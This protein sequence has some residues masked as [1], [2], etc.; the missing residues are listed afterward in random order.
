MDTRRVRRDVF[1]TAAVFAL[2]GMMIGSWNARIPAVKEHL[3]VSLGMMG[4]I[5]LCMGLGSL[6][7]MPFTGAVLKRVDIRIVNTALPLVAGSVFTLLPHVHN[8]GAFAAL[9]ALTGFCWGAWDV[10]INVQAS[11]VERESKW[12]IMPALHG[13][14]GAGML[15]G[16]LAGYFFARA[17]VSLAT[18]IGIVIPLVAL[19][20][21]ACGLTWLDYR[22]STDAHHAD[23]V[24]PKLGALV[25]PAVL[26]GTMMLASTIGEGS[27]SDWLALHMVEDRG[28]S[29]ALGASVYVVYALFLTV[30]R[31][32]GSLIIK[33]LGRVRAI[34]VSGVVTFLGVMT[35]ILA[36]GLWASYLGAALWGFGLAVVFPAGISIAGERGGA[37]AS[38]LIS[39]VSTMAYGGFLMGPAVLGFV[40]NHWGLERALLIP[41]VLGLVFASL[42]KFAAQEPGAGRSTA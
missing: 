26:I 32:L 19:A 18:H 31:L 6:V 10:A 41:A 9:Y 40:A 13:M 33:A 38:H 42:A 35:V 4:L 30:S 36:P 29:A 8:V 39:W 3:D 14:W 2:N 24:A 11:A 17:E 16:A 21:I 22:A 37:N 5:F 7:S 15:I 12:T 20:A 28:S 27:A 1:T 23:S 25:L 34:Q